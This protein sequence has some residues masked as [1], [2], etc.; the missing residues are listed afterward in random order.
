MPVS[1]STTSNKPRLDRGIPGETEDARPSMQLIIP[2][3]ASSEKSPTVPVPVARMAPLALGVKTSESNVGHSRIRQQATTSRHESPKDSD[4][5][6][7]RIPPQAE[8][9]QTTRGV[10][11][12]LKA[13]AAVIDAPITTCIASVGSPV[14]ASVLN[15]LSDTTKPQFDTHIAGLGSF[16][17]AS[18]EPQNQHHVSGTSDPPAQELRKQKG[19]HRSRA[20]SELI[21]HILV[22]EDET[23]PNKDPRPNYSY[24]ELAEAALL[25]APGH[26]LQ[27]WQVVKWVY[28]NVAGY[29][30]QDQDLK[31]G[32]SSVLSATARKATGSIISEEPKT[33]DTKQT[34][35][36]LLRPSSKHLIRPWDK[37]KK[38][39][40]TPSGVSIATVS[41]VGSQVKGPTHKDASGGST[42]RQGRRKTGNLLL[43]RPTGG[44]KSSTRHTSNRGTSAPKQNLGPSL[45][46]ESARNTEPKRRNPSPTAERPAKRR[47]LDDPSGIV[48]GEAVDGNESE[49][50]ASG[51]LPHQP[52]ASQTR[53]TLA[54]EVQGGGA[55]HSEGSRSS[56]SAKATPNRIMGTF[57]IDDDD[58]EGESVQRP[59]LPRIVAESRTEDILVI[60]TTDLAMVQDPQRLN[61]SE[62]QATWE[63]VQDSYA[64]DTGTVLELPDLTQDEPTTTGN[65]VQGS[66]EPNGEASLQIH[67]PTIAAEPPS[68][69]AS[70]HENALP[71]QP[72]ELPHDHVPVEPPEPP[73]EQIDVDMIL[74]SVTPPSVH[75]EPNT[76]PNQISAA[77]I[78]HNARVLAAIRNRQRQLFPTLSQIQLPKRL[79][80]VPLMEIE[81]RPT[82]KRL[83][84]AGPEWSR[85]GHNT[86]LERMEIVNTSIQRAAPP[87]GPLNAPANDGM[88]DID[89]EGAD[90]GFGMGYGNLT[91]SQEPEEY[92]NLDDLLGVPAKVEFKVQDGHLVV[93]DAGATSRVSISALRLTPRTY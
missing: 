35:W 78:E 13:Q 59:V 58:S 91:S 50:A 43:E 3:V 82:R 62:D 65:A 74:D 1:D 56:I 20:E 23:I 73:I 60:Q 6:I 8:L 72:D 49:A 86:A 77:R 12:E 69:V 80:P 85:L 15:G 34:K 37:K 10:N 25:D 40:G 75:D 52:F 14:S 55:I 54:Q 42:R 19:A 64:D 81:A 2:P 36:W 24:R 4:E 5:T 47:H 45:L 26:R 53:G 70:S 44:V 89:A 31:A 29:S 48:H 9:T 21:D 7:R 76:Q 57:V 38:S 87:K 93:V 88:A 22:Q 39:L 71:L 63:L 90:Y 33:G 27:A 17:S 28:S 30:S 32:I 66:D 83:M 46:K 61:M 11:A 41:P 18:A 79:K 92:D 84:R 67:E 51:Q 68:A 16:T